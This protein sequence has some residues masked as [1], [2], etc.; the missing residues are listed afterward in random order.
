[1]FLG[2]AD[3]PDERD[4]VYISDED[5]DLEEEE[6]S[7]DRPT[8]ASKGKGKKVEDDVVQ[9]A[10][11][12]CHKHSGQ[13]FQC[14]R[15]RSPAASTSTR[16]NIKRGRSAEASASSK[17]DGG[18]SSKFASAKKAAPSGL[19]DA[20]PPARGKSSFDV[21]EII[22]GKRDSFCLHVICAS[23]FV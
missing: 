4:A 13:S 17:K 10:G 3:E 16:S 1:M 15:S 11:T 14:H 19:H 9:G 6:Y 12:K 22:S 8:A 23:S 18:S 2:S 7:S 21:A 5:Q 20:K